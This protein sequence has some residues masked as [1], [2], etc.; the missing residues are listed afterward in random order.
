MTRTIIKGGQQDEAWRNLRLGCATASG[1]SNVLAKGKGSEES[2]TRRNYL[3][4]LALE[5]LTGVLEHDDL[6]WNKNIALG[7]EREPLGRQAF[8]E[9]T[10]HL[11]EEVSFI[12]LDAMPVGCSPDGLIGDNAGFELKSPSK[13]V[14]FEYLSLTT[15]PPA[16]YQAQVQGCMYVTGRSHWYFATFNP[17]FPPELQLHWIRVER[18][19]L[20]IKRLEDELWKF[21]FEVKE[22]VKR[23][24][25]MIAD[26]KAA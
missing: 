6:S 5:I 11:I 18:D 16:V 14:H 13:A 19:D 26:R 17:E 10:G 1:F 9:A 20:Y 15:A 23:M 7:I 2:V 22:A 12:K 3:I 4:R 8:E 21:N 25:Q 24:R